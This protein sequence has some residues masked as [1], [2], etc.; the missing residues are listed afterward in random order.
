MPSLL[1]CRG[2]FDYEHGHRK[3]DIVINAQDNGIFRPR[4][5]ADP[6]RIEVYINNTNDRKP[7]FVLP[8]YSEFS[9]ALNLLPAERS[10]RSQELSFL[11]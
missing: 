1:L 7:S 6:A 3:F 8:S 10:R 9:E 2:L 5:A 4:R 11:L